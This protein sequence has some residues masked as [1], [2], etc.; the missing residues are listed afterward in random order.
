M[1][2]NASKREGLAM[3]KYRR[4]RMRRDIKW[5]KEGEWIKYLG[6]PVG[7]DLDHERN[8]GVRR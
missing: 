8:G 6:V 7:N 4:K 1:R 2:E 3:G 5:C